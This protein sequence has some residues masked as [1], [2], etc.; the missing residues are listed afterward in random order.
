QC[1]LEPQY[2]AVSSLWINSRSPRVQN[3]NDQ[4]VLV[5]HDQIDS[6]RGVELRLWE[7]ECLKKQRDSCI[8]TQEPTC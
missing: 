1:L 8:K 4:Q 2:L 7:P 6:V 5:Q 3:P